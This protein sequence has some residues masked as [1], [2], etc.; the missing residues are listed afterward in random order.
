V[1]NRG[2][3]LIELLISIALFGLIAASAMSL[4]MSGVRMQSH[5]ARVDVAQSGLR[6]GLDF[7]TR[8]IMMA[9]AGAAATGK[10]IDGTSGAVIVPIVVTDGGSS[11]TDKLDLYLVDASV[12]ATVT[13]TIPTSAA[14]VTVNSTTGFA[15]NDWIEITDYTNALLFKQS[16]STPGTTQLTPTTAINYGTIA[17]TYAPGALAF[18]VR[19]VTYAINSTMYAGSGVTTENG[20]ALTMDLNDGNGPQPLAEGIEDLQVALGFDNNANGSITDDLGAAANGDEWVYNNASDT[21]PASL[22]NLKVLRIT[23]VAKS[24]SQE[25]GPSTPRPAAEDHSAG[26]ADG[27]FRRTVR[28]LITVRNFNL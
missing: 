19:H 6:A 1:R 8:D 4:V 15:A 11:G 28:S 23:L 21:P 17:S 18:K 26:T 16:T 9:S 22:A 7:M 20:A 5:S 27:Y 12:N 2:F 10:M 3:T 14:T 24:T 25:Q 13:A